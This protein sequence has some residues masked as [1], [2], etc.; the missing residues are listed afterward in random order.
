MAPARPREESD[1]AETEPC[2]P[3]ENTAAVVDAN[4]NF[5]AIIAS[6]NSIEAAA[7]SGP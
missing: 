6:C 3:D 1:S 7:S 2:G 4:V 5:S